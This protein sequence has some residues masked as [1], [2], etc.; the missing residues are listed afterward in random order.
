L[1]LAVVGSAVHWTFGSISTPLLVQ[2]LLGGVPG[3]LLGCLL[4]RKVP[5][6]RLKAIV[7][8]IAICAGLQLVWSGT[9]SLAV[10]NGVNALKSWTEFAK[11]V[12]P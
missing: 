9:H 11:T 2:L 6:R 5:A 8:G 12:R 10:R 7:A 1:V 4:A 3:V